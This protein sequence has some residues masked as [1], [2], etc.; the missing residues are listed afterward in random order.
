LCSN[1]CS[2]LVKKQEKKEKIEKKKKKKIPVKRLY[3]LFY[4]NEE[5]SRVFKFISEDLKI[6][7]IGETVCRALDFISCTVLVYFLFY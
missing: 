5:F 2:S 7:T 4:P 3:R 6:L 1:L